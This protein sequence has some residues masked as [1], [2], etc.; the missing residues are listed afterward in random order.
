LGNKS[1]IKQIRLRPIVET[2]KDIRGQILFSSQPIAFL[3]GV[4]PERGII[5]QNKHELFQSPVAGKILVFPNAVGSSVGAYV[6]YRLRMNRVAPKAMVNQRA[7]IITASGCA[8][9]GIPLFDM[10]ADSIEVLRNVVMGRIEAKESLLTFGLN[11]ANDDR[12]E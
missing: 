3:Q 5:T 10:P 4:D 7:D 11:L 6:I 2:S 8:I 9:G 12:G 1:K